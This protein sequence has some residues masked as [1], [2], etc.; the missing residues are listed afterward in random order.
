M[1]LVRFYQ[2]LN[3]TKYLIV[4]FALLWRVFIAVEYRGYSD[5][6]STLS[7][8]Q[9]RSHGTN[10]ISLACAIQQ[11]TTS[12]EGNTY[13]SWNLGAI[14]PPPDTWD[15]SG[16]Y[17][18]RLFYGRAASKP[19]TLPSQIRQFGHFKIKAIPTGPLFTLITSNDMFVSAGLHVPVLTI[20]APFMLLAR[21]F[22]LTKRQFPGRTKGSFDGL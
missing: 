13:V 5:K 16:I 17:S 19:A 3:M 15:S 20:N 21:S 14:C 4:T 18:G 6:I 7:T 8:L 22:K 10:C 2:V 11:H 9:T 1:T 12:Y